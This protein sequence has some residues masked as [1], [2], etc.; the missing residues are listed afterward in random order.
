MNTKFPFSIKPQ[1]WYDY[2]N[3]LWYRKRRV[4]L[5]VMEHVWK[6]EGLEQKMNNAIRDAFIYGT[7]RADLT[8]DYREERS[9]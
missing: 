6:T 1:H 9:K 5:V 8:S 7:G 4:V 2:L 3:P